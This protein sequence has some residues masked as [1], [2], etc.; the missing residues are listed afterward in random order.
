MEATTKTVLMIVYMLLLWTIGSYCVFR[1]R[2]VQAFSLKAHEKGHTPSGAYFR[3]YLQSN[4][5]VFSIRCVG[6]G[7]YL[8]AGLLAVALF[9]SW[10]FWLPW[11]IGQKLTPGSVV[12]RK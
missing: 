1:P 10:G 5:Y 8:M 12:A 2:N 11:S 6:L 3:K 4:G 7:A 9:R